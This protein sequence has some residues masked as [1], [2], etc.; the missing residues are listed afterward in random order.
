[1]M[2]RKSEATKERAA[3][4]AVQKWNPGKAPAKKDRTA[5]VKALAKDEK[6]TFAGACR[7]LMGK[8][9]DNASVLEALTEL[10]IATDEIKVAAQRRAL[11]RQGV[12]T[13]I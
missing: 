5:T 1:M 3:P 7:D 10:R 12:V 13:S 4:A 8:G 2:A 9:W 6:L 11:G